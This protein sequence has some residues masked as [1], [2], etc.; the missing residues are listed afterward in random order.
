MALASGV[1]CGPSP[2]TST[3]YAAAL[4]ELRRRARGMR[5]KDEEDA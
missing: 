3:R 4:E 5:K 2:M 1:C